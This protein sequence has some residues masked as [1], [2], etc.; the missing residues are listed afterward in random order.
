MKAAIIAGCVALSMLSA[1]AA[2]AQTNGT[3]TLACQGN[4]EHRPPLHGDSY[5]V[6][7][8]YE[9]PISV[10]IIITLPTAA[11]NGTVDGDL[12]VFPTN[13]ATIAEIS[14]TNVAFSG[15]HED[16]FIRGSIDRITGDLEAFYSGK[17]ETTVVSLKCKPAQ[18]IF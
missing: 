12:Y 14:Q 5:T 4:L 3:L 2:H 10:G 13:G 1:S 6:N 16:G 11:R 18:R 17:W 8:D 9:E 7:P 15:P